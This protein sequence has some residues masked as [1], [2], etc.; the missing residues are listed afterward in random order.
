MKNKHR[1]KSTV[2]VLILQVPESERKEKRFFFL[3]DLVPVRDRRGSVESRDQ[4][5]SAGQSGERGGKE[6]WT[7][8]KKKERISCTVCSCGASGLL[9]S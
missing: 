7:V 8:T 3:K 4:Y 1:R 6:S 2:F 9:S 5:R